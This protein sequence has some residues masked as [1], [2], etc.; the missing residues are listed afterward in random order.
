[1]G[2]PVMEK[3]LQAQERFVHDD[4]LWTKYMLREKAIRDYN[5]D[6]KEAHETGFAQ[7]MELGEAQGVEKGVTKNRLETAL[8]MLQDGVPLDLI[9]KYTALSPD[10]LVSLAKEYHIDT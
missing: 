10:D 2:D 5:S 7:G 8:A 6:I 3:V 4:A 9:T 1:M